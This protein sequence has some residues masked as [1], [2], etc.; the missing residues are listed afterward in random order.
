LRET[1]RGLLYDG[2]QTIAS[3]TVLTINRLEPMPTGFIADLQQRPRTRILENLRAAD[4]GLSVSF[5]G[6]AAP[7]QTD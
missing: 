1:H 7:G 2:R 4:I 5:P 3:T 6:T